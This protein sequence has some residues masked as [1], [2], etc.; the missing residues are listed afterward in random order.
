MWGVKKEKKNWQNKWIGGMAMGECKDWQ[1][2][3]YIIQTNYKH[4]K[5]GY[6]IVAT[7]ALNSRPRQGLVK[8]R[9]KSEAQKSH[10]MLPRV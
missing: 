8:V 2:K 7:F 3:F 4:Y 10:F 6:G 1:R 9:T 5:R